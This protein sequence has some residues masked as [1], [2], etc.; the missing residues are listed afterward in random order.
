MELSRAKNP[1]FS[2]VIPTQLTCSPEYQPTDSHS[3]GT[4]DQ[5]ENLF[6][7]IRSFLIYFFMYFFKKKKGQ[8]NSD[9]QLDF[10]GKKK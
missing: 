2:P 8:L 1:N 3:T 5:F 6:L 4:T 10:L 7:I 9:Q